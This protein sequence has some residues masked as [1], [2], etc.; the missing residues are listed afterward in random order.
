[1]ST[2]CQ[3]LSQGLKGPASLIIELGTELWPENS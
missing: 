3:G 2:F 1:M